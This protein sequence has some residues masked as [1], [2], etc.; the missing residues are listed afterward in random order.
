LALAIAAAA[1]V[2]GCGG[3]SGPT[4]TAAPAQRAE[5][6]GPRTA[7]TTADLE[8][9]ADEGE[10]Q[11]PVTV[12]DATGSSV[13]IESADRILALDTY[14]TLGTTVYALGLGDR[15]VGRDVST[16]VEELADLPLVT[17]NGHE[18]NGE[19]IL[20]LDPDVVLTDDSIGP[21]EVQ[22]QL[23]ASGIP[24]VFLDGQR[25]A[26]RIAPQIRAVAQALGVP[27]RGDRLVERVEGEVAEAQA[28]VDRWRQ[29]AGGEAQRMV[30]LYLRGNAGVYYWFGE[31][32]GADDLIDA[33]G[34]VDVA[35]ESGLSGS[36]PVNAEGLVS[37]EPDLY[38]MMTDG[39][40]SVGG[41]EGLLEVPGVADTEA[42][43][44]GCVVDMADTRILSFGPQYPDTLRALGAAIYSTEAAAAAG[45]ESDR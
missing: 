35:S 31:G 1:V 6:P 3:G 19:A 38:L 15:L 10:P 24:V 42:G 21:I 12:T 29:D 4:G 39:L 7:D 18:L 41:V 25:S 44:N 16:G 40:A 32:S 45:E 5:C 34:G 37:T 17:R 30:F 33:L 26:D 22:Y 8:P 27:E 9:L 11:L 43:Q 20:E 2:A 14:G 23:Q 28:D 13:T 36:K